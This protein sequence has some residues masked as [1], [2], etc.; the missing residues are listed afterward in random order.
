MSRLARFVPALASLAAAVIP[1]TAVAESYWDTLEWQVRPLVLVE[2]GPE[3][4]DWTGRLL[5]DRCALVE[6]RIHWLVIE[7]NGTVQRRFDG[8]E[9]AEFE[10]TT[11]DEEAASNVRERV[12]WSSGDGTRLQLFGLDGQEKYRGQP[13]GLDTIWSLID[14]MPMRRAE[15]GREP[16]DCRD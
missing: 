10:S 14:G 15:M 1:T 3:A 2:G 5:G 4:D 12:G 13:D 11:L 6:R 8:G 16:D 7:E 9:T